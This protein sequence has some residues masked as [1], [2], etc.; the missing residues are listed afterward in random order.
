MG[1]LPHGSF[2]L[3]HGDVIEKM[4][5]KYPHAHVVTLL[6][7]LLS[8]FFGFPTLLTQFSLYINDENLPEPDFAVLK[9][10]APSL[11]DGGHVRAEDVQLIIEVSD[12][13]LSSDLTT[14]AVL[15]AGAGIPEYWVVDVN[16]RCLIIHDSPH[17]AGYTQVIT[18]SETETA[19][20]R[21]FPTCIFPVS[22]ILP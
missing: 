17:V 5:T 6:F 21:S 13:T 2:E 18:Y 15:Y 20:P 14:K 12:A 11:T 22:E 10:S 7:A 16:G 19:S 1:L 3:L 9:S 4:P 8:R